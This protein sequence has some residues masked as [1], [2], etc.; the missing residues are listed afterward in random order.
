MPGASRSTNHGA[1]LPPPSEREPRHYSELLGSPR[2]PSFSKRLPSPSLY[3]VLPSASSLAGSPCSLCPRRF[4]HT[5][6]TDRVRMLLFVPRL[7]VLQ[8]SNPS[9]FI[10]LLLQIVGRNEEKEF[11]SREQ[12]TVSRVFN[13]FRR[14]SFFSHFSSPRVNLF[15]PLSPLLPHH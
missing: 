1:P 11:M 2:L 14:R 8:N 7:P 5:S 3:R 4:S 6:A 12:V 15:R 10:F 9:R 13:F